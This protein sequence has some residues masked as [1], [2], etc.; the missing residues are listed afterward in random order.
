MA[1]PVVGSLVVP[2]PTYRTQ[3][4]T[5]DGAAVLLGVRRSSGHIFYPGTDR[6]FWVPTRQIGEIPAE[7]VP[8]GSQEHFFSR[9]LVFLEAE[10]CTLLEYDGGTAELEITYPG[11]S[12]NG[13][14]ELV[15]MLGDTLIDYTI[16]PGSMQVALLELRL[17]NLPAPAP[18]PPSK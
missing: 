8:P 1:I 15:S 7:A 3:M 11:I 5:G 4:S 14:I 12:R 13:L 18:M 16:K 9:L 2:A 6:E 17:A 10:E